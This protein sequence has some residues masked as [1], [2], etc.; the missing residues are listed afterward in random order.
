MPRRLSAFG[1]TPEALR[2]CSVSIGVLTLIS[3]FLLVRSLVAN[4]ILACFATTLLAI[5][6]TFV[7]GTRNGFICASILLLFLNAAFINL[8]NWRRTRQARGL[9]LGCLFLGC[10]MSCRGWFIYPLFALAVLG[11]AYEK[12]FLISEFKTAPRRL[13]RLLLGAVSCL[14]LGS[15]LFILTLIWNHHL[16]IPKNLIPSASVAGSIGVSDYSHTLQTRALQF[17]ALV[18]RDALLDMQFPEPNDYGFYGPLFYACLLWLT[19]SLFQ[20]RA[21]FS[22]SKK[23]FFLCFI[24]AFL[25]FSPLTLSDHKLQHLFSL[26]PIAIILIALAVGELGHRLRVPW[27]IASLVGVLGAGLVLD[28]PQIQD[29]LRTMQGVSA[30]YSDAIYGLASWIKQNQVLRLGALDWGFHDNL[31]YL[32]AGAVQVDNLTDPDSAKL[33]AAKLAAGLKPGGL[34][35]T[36]APFD[37]QDFT[38]PSART[39]S[40]QARQ[41]GLKVS[42]A[43]RWV[44]RDGNLAILLLRLD[45]A[46]PGPEAM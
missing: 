11:F 26:F 21:R 22:R 20:R 16:V 25:V 18:N 5:H 35:V 32:L 36:Y 17:L 27:R 14:S 1:T 19:I 12:S 30:T 13:A 9:W 33:S 41:A 42:P 34:Y 15:I 40:F 45:S 39:L 6:P 2:L 23:I 7:S 29:R 46:R 10:G 44:Q 8:L 43:Q 24:P 31:T 28:K 3:F 37:G 4:G 38:S